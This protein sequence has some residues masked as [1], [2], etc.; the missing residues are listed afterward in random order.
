MTA[1]I[2]SSHAG[3]L[4]EIGSFYEGERVARIAVQIGRAE[5]VDLEIET[6]VNWGAVLASRGKVDEACTVWCRC[7]RLAQNLDYQSIAPVTLCFLARALLRMGRQ[8][9]A[10]QIAEL[11]WL[12]ARTGRDHPRD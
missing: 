11:A 9:E 7:L 10:R 8:E 3:C 2:F 5:R 4:N 6:L 1:L 12:Q